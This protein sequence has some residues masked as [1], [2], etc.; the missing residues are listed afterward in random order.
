M[1]RADRISRLRK[2]LEI[3]KAQCSFCCVGFELM[4]EASDAESPTLPLL[5]RHVF[6]P[7]A[8]M[9]FSQTVVKGRRTQI[10]ST[11]DTDSR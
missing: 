4:F 3:R 7:T 5:L 10:E 11:G 9:F 6:P 8:Y 1:A 2:N